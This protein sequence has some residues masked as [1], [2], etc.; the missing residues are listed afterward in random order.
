MIIDGRCNLPVD[1]REFSNRFVNFCF[2]RALVDTNRALASGT[3]D[4]I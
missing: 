3:E 1:E 2:V 4:T